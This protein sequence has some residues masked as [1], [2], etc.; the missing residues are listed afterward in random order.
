ME[1]NYYKEIKKTFNRKFAEIEKFYEESFKVN[2]KICKNRIEPEINYSTCMSEF[3]SLWITSLNNLQE[4][5]NRI[6]FDFDA[7]INA[8]SQDHKKC[9]DSAIKE[10][11]KLKIE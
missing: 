6:T 2:Q 5:L 9:S 1:E 11:K 8:D 7:C 3:E 4:K 10:L